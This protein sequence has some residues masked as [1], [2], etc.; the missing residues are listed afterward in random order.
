[1]HGT[2]SAGRGEIPG[3]SLK[4]VASLKQL[5]K[6]TKTLLIFFLTSQYNQ[7]DFRK[8]ENHRCL[9]I[10]RKA[11]GQVYQPLRIKSLSTI[12]TGSSFLE[13]KGVFTLNLIYIALGRA[14]AP[15]PGTRMSGWVP[16]TTTSGRHRSGRL[17]SQVPWAKMKAKL[18]AGKEGREVSLFPDCTVTCEENL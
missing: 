4:F 18:R 1:M 12:K 2:R 13:L 9:D 10:C 3:P 5:S 11:S 14:P 15:P 8:E 6:Q 17:P 7:P 16:T